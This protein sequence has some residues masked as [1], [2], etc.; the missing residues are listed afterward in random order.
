M[1]I[2]Y[3]STPHP[4]NGVAPYEALKGTPVRMNLDYIEPKPQ[5]DERDGII[6]GRDAEYK[7]EATE[8]R[9]KDQRE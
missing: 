9:E 7:H 5:R 2:A 8:R 4:A 1:L 6:D 3:R